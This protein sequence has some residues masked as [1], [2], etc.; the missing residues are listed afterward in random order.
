MKF[1]IDDETE[2]VN[3]AVQNQLAAT[4]DISV[5]F[6]RITNVRVSSAGKKAPTIHE[7]DK[8]PEKALKGS[9]VSLK[10]QYNSKRALNFLSP[11]TG[12]ID[13]IPSNALHQ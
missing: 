10:T 8:V 5:S 12:W 4:G 9:A 3:T 1:L 2:P 6:Y 7:Y 11:L 13:L